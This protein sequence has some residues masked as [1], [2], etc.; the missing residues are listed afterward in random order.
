MD[1]P[2]PTIVIVVVLAPDFHH[3]P[4]YCNR[5]SEKIAWRQTEPRIR[6]FADAF[7]D[8]TMLTPYV[9]AH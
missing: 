8:G 7:S 6:S 3:A 2:K 4:K 5:E 1:K 9:W